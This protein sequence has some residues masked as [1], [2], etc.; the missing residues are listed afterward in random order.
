MFS[1]LE[2]S[3]WFKTYLQ[4]NSYHLKTVLFNTLEVTPARIWSQISF[5]ICFD[6]LLEAV[7]RVFHHKLCIYFWIKHINL[8]QNFIHRRLSRL[9]EK[10]KKIRKN[11]FPFL[12]SYSSRLSPSCLPCF[13]KQE[14]CCCCFGLLRDNKYVKVQIENSRIRNSMS[15]EI[16]TGEGNHA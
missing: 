6:Y 9:E 15:G 10:V 3:L 8:F 11:P 16:T 12:F 5:L 13:K 1:L 2:N 4:V 7:Q 14:T